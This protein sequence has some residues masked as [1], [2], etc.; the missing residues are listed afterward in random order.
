MVGNMVK[1]D[2]MLIHDRTHNWMELKGPLRP[3]LKILEN[4]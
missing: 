3:E 4:N 1:S 2:E